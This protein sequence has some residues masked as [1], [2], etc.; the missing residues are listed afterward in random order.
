MIHPVGPNGR[1]LLIGKQFDGMMQIRSLSRLK[2][3]S[4]AE[5]LSNVAILSI[6]HKT[7]Q[8]SQWSVKYF[9][10]QFDIVKS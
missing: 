7:S 5:E 3:L 4:F 1:R 2:K 9:D 10:F 6:R 8:K